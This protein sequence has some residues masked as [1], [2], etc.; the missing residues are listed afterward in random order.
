M[1]ADAVTFAAVSWYWF[2]HC[3]FI[4]S[5]GVLH[6]FPL[7]AIWYLSKT[8]IAS[9]C[10][11]LKNLNAWIHIKTVSNL[12]MFSPSFAAMRSLPTSFY[13][14]PITLSYLQWKLQVSYLPQA[15]SLEVLF[16]YFCGCAMWLRYLHATSK[17]LSGPRGLYKSVPFTGFQ[18]FSA[19][20]LL[21]FSC[22]GIQLLKCSR[23]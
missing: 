2:D 17:G 19:E 10:Q 22:P 6:Y 5:M 21:K 14:L 16:Q 13:L 11:V 1:S 3:L 4:Q 15:L 23:R 18:P 7:D 12:S 20:S 8:S 9:L